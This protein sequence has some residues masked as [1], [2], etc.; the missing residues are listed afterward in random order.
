[1]TIIQLQQVSQQPTTVEESIGQALFSQC[2]AH[3]TQYL[4]HSGLGLSYSSCNAAVA[5]NLNTAYG[6][7]SLTGGHQFSVAYGSS[8]LYSGL[9]PAFNAMHAHI[10]P[11][12]PFS[13]SQ[14]EEHAEQ[15]AIR[16]VENDAAL[17][18]WTYGGNHHIYI[19]LSPCSSCHAWLTN[20]ALN[21]YVH[22]RTPLSQQSA[23]VKEK[24][25]ARSNEFGRQ[26]ETR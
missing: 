26:M 7:V 21:W 8:R 15:C 23:V 3:F 13:S 24:K 19:D 20:H 11:N 14:L 16:R 2:M 5:V 4:G 6:L 1:M 17:A 12:S 25:Q 18:F 22:Y 10:A 9:D